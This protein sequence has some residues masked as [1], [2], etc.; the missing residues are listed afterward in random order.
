VA[1]DIL[2]WNATLAPDAVPDGF[3][4]AQVL[5]MGSLWAGK[6]VTTAARVGGISRSTLRR[7]LA[8]DPAFLAYYNQARKEM[9][10]AVEQGLRLLSGSAVVALRRL[11]TRRSVP[12]SVKPQASVAVLKLTTRPVEGPTEVEDA[13]NALLL[14]KKKRDLETM[15]ATIGTGK[16]DLRDQFGRPIEAAEPDDLDEGEDDFDEAGD[17]LEDVE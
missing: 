2:L 12:D 15:M 14:R 16:L 8:D 6:R 1:R 7:W 3:T 4:P 9:A 5:A 10:D 11:S 13:T 17:D